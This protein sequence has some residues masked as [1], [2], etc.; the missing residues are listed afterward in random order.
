M[1]KLPILHCVIVEGEKLPVGLRK[2]NVWLLKTSIDLLN[3]SAGEQ[4][5]K[6]G[7]DDTRPSP[8]TGLSRDSDGMSGARQATGPQERSLQGVE[9]GY[10]RQ[11]LCKR[12][13]Q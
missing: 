4:W 2:A 5:R 8:G 7:S 11:Q 10:K 3:S 9:S 6:V 13:Y 12:V 1:G